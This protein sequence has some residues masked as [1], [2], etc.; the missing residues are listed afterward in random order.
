MSSFSFFLNI[1][2]H[3]NGLHLTGKLQI[4]QVSF[5]KLH[6]ISLWTASFQYSASGDVY[7]SVEVFWCIIHKINNK[8]ISKGFFSALSL[9]H[10]RSIYTVILS[11]LFSINRR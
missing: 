11:L 10:S 9:A 2:L 1:H 6:S 4:S 3:P 8:V 5:V 7:A